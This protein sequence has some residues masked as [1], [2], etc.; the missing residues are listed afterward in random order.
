MRRQG[1]VGGGG[2]SRCAACAGFRPDIT[3][4]FLN[5]ALIADYLL[6]FYVLLSV[7]LDLTIFNLQSRRI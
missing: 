6:C 2:G 1:I 7:H 4:L 3:S 5:D